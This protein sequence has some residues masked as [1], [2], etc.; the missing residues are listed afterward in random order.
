[1]KKI[2][3]QL[4]FAEPLIDVYPHHALAFGI[5]Q[6][7]IYD[8]P[9]LLT[10]YIQL[11][12]DTRI[13]RMDFSFGLDILSYLKDIPLLFCHQIDR[14][15][16]HY[17]WKTFSRFLMN[18]INNGYYVHCLV[19]TYYI[20]AY[21]DCYMRNHLYHNITVYGY[22]EKNGVF[23]TA[24]SFV[25]GRFVNREV[26]M[27]ELDNSFFETRENDWLDGILLYRVKE[28]PYIGIGYDTRYMK[29]DIRNYIEGIPSGEISIKEKRRRIQD[30]YV[31]GIQVYDRLISYLEYVRDED[32]VIDIRLI[33]V[34]MD[35]KK[36]L[37]HIMN[38]LHSIALLENID[39]NRQNV[40]SL[41]ERLEAISGKMLKYNILKDMELLNDIMDNLRT[42]MENDYNVMEFFYETI[43]TAPM[44][45]EYKGEGKG[46][47]CIFEEK[48]KSLYGN[49]EKQ[50]GSR[51]YHIIGLKKNLPEYIKEDNYIFRNAVYVLLRRQYGEEAALRAPDNKDERLI[52]YYLNGEEM[53]LEIKFEDDMEHRVTFYCVDYDRLERRQIVDVLDGATGEC[54]HREEVECFHYGVY[55]QYRMKG[56]VVVRFRKIEGPDAVLSGVFFD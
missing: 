28:D 33:S 52:G 4:P 40:T 44:L 55:L 3:K 34:L 15:F 54:L 2:Q 41:M 49:W 9:S 14:G 31:Y 17:N 12:Y 6:N 7:N 53:S 38:Q 37:I 48:K 36:I 46:N 23:Y 8:L 43:Q 10:N 21:E 13:D 51:G 30:E 22:D 50:Y 25:H 32:E 35:H 56:H 26:T 16:V 5:L 29:D 19:D 42:A 27:T 45:L 18:C 47:I 39:E 1:M 24:D 20:G 11:V